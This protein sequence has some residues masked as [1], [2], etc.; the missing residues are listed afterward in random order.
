MEENLPHNLDRIYCY[1]MWLTKITTVDVIMHHN[2]MQKKIYTVNV[3]ESR[4]LHSILFGI[5]IFFF[6]AFYAFVS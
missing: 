5:F 1:Q 3:L 4:K 2:I 6:Y